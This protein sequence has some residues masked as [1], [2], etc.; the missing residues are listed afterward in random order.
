VTEETMTANGSDLMFD[1]FKPRPRDQLPQVLAELLERFPV[2]PT[3]SDIWVVSLFDDV[4][5]PQS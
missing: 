3:S 1:P 5:T 2:Y 4:E